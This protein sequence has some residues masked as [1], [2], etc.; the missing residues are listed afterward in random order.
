MGC[1]PSSLNNNKVGILDDEPI[2]KKHFDIERVIGQGGFG[3]VRERRR[4]TDGELP[5]LGRGSTTAPAS[6]STAST[7]TG[8][9]TSGKWRMEPNYCGG[10][11][12]RT[13]RY[14]ALVPG[15]E[16]KMMDERTGTVAGK[17]N[18]MGRGGGCAVCA[19][20]VR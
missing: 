16:G 19:V 13:A 15:S 2:N 9:H 1:G 18:G 7:A 6:R 17:D 12:N 3:K 20:S 4:C 10:P 14:M 8:V 5:G 11:V